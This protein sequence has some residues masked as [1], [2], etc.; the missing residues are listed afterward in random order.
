MTKETLGKIL[1][2]GISLIA[3]TAVVVVAIFYSYSENQV[4]ENLN[5]VEAVVEAELKQS[6]YHAFINNGLDED[7]RSRVELVLKLYKSEK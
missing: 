1:A 3:I 6:T 7:T 2:F 5:A 4:K